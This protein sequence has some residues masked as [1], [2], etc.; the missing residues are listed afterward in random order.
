MRH[1]I[2]GG[3]V[4]WTIIDRPG[5]EDYEYLRAK[6]DISPLTLGALKDTKAFPRLLTGDKVSFLSWYYLAPTDGKTPMRFACLFGP[7]FLVTVQNG[8]A[9]PID[10]IAAAAETQPDI[11]GNGLGVLLY[12]ILDAATDEYFLDVDSLSDTVDDMEDRMLDK[13]TSQE[14]KTLFALKRRMLQLRRIVAP[15]REVINSLL[16]RNL[17][18]VEQ[19]SRIYMED[20]LDHCIRVVDLIDTLRDVTSGAMQIYQATISNNL[21]A[22]MKQLTII[23]TIMMPLTLI[24]GIFGMNLGFPGGKRQSD[25]GSSWSRS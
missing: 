20:L 12:N 19:G 4:T 21:N 6:F 16:R 18:Y 2:T 1:A 13:P 3:G 8:P 25:S 15:E 24:S 14:V 11:M 5:E 23:A 22:V 7:D 17:P 9:A 10:E